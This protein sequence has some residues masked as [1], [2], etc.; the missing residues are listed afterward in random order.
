MSYGYHNRIVANLGL[1]G[2]LTGNGSSR[3]VS[4]V[5]FYLP[6]HAQLVGIYGHCSACATGGTSTLNVCCGGATYKA[7]T[8][9]CALSSGTISAANTSILGNYAKHDAGVVF[10]LT[11]TTTNGVAVT[12]PGVTLVF[13]SLDA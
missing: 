2:A 6:C 3:A 11:E 12:N 4:C 7:T 10:T 1:I 5:G 13:R 8:S 9:G